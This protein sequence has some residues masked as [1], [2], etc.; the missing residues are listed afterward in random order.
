MV[1]IDAKPKLTGN[2]PSGVRSKSELVSRGLVHAKRRF[3]GLS[4]T[5]RRR[6]IGHC[7][8]VLR[9]HPGCYVLHLD[10]MIMESYSTEARPERLH[11]RR[12]SSLN[13]G[14]SRLRGALSA[15]NHPSLLGASNPHSETMSDDHFGLESRTAR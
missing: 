14:G 12:E 11:P 3:A 10:R 2:C 4:I 9:R 6:V 1:P 15:G 13:G 8:S 5:R 7:V